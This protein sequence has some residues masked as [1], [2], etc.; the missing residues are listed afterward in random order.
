MCVMPGSKEL[1]CAQALKEALYLGGGEEEP[2]LPRLWCV[3]V[4]GGLE[5]ALAGGR[6]ELGVREERLSPALAA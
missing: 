1:P 5:K 6:E 3:L 4:L 2:V